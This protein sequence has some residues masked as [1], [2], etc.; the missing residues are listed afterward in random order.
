[1]NANQPDP[2]RRPRRVELRPFPAARRIVTGSIRAGRRMAPI[3]GL[4]PVDVTEARRRM[5]AM[6][7]PPSLTAYVVACVARAAAQHPEA[8]AY[9]DW[10]GRLVVTHHVDVGMLVETPTDAGPLPVGHVVRDADVRSVAEISAEVRGVHAR[11]DSGSGN[12]SLTRLSMTTRIPGAM[13]LFFRTMQ[14]SVWLHRA[15]GTVSVSSVGM[16]GRGSGFAVA[17][18]AVLTLNVFVGGLSERPWAVDG[19]VDVREVLDLTVTVD[20]NVVDG[21]P[22]ARFVASMR[23]LVESASLLPVAVDG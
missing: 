19:R 7:P 10:R 3:H 12:R 11:P 20:H 14:R 15:S 2:R 21:A 5:A 17:A 18:P 6:S 22:A 8:H 1:M 13:P 9:R 4:I 16:F 23:E